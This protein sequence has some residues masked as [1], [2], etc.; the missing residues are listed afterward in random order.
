MFLFFF[1]AGGVYL[2]SSSPR[3]EETLNSGVIK[4]ADQLGSSKGMEL[5]GLKEVTRI[6]KDSESSIQSGDVDVIYVHVCGS[7]V[8]PGVYEVAKKDRAI[9]AIT[10]AGGFCQGAAKDAINLAQ[11]LMDEQRL[12][13]PSQEEVEKGLYQVEQAVNISLD[14][15]N[16]S[17]VNINVAS[18]EELMTLP[19]IG[20][21]KAESI[22]SFREEHDGFQS[23]EDLQKITG[24]KQAIFQ[25]VKDY[26]T[27][28]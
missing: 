26:I 4:A 19:G 3:N 21:A 5:K 12:Y 14:E 2:Y 18:K 22:I 10:K 28:E 24:I 1:I 9:D 23:I 7:V 20:E 13:I 16:G 25:K 11:L 15:E 17:Q 6:E 27:I 8:S